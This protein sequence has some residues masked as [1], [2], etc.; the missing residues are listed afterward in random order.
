MQLPGDS[1]SVVGVSRG[2]GFYTAVRL[3]VQR[4]AD[5]VM[6]RRYATTLCNDENMRTHQKL[7]EMRVRPLAGLEDALGKVD[8]ARE[9]FEPQEHRPRR[10]RAIHTVSV[11]N[12]SVDA[13]FWPNCSHLMPPFRT[14]TRASAASRGPQGGHCAHGSGSRL[15]AAEQPSLVSCGSS[16]LGECQCCGPSC[17]S[18][19]VWRR[20]K[21]VP[22][23]SGNSRM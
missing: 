18:R 17:S 6:Q 12:D 4:E 13:E 22:W 20:D 19:G 21:K 15:G 10:H 16:R 11:S 7:L 14:R 23:M 2:R 5:H 8:A 3:R 9:L 1:S